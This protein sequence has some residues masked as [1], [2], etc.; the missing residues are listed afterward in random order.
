MDFKNIDKKYRPVPFWSWNEKLDTKET[1]RQI[2]I[3]DKAGIGGYFMHARGGLETEY[4]GKEWFDNVEVGITEG[5]KRGMEAWAYDE[6]GWPSGFG[7]GMVNGLG[8][9]YQQKYLR[10]EKYS[11]HGENTICVKDGYRFYYD[12]NP[13]YVDTLSEEVVA[14]FI[15]KIYKP[16]YEKYG[17]GFKG[18]FTDEPQISRNGIP[19]SLTL[20]NEYKKA[21]GEDLT[22]VLKELFYDVGDYK[23]TRIKFYKL[24]TD[25]FSKNFMKQIYDWCTEHGLEFTGHLVCEDTPA[26]QLLCNGACMPHYEYLHMPGI[27]CLGRGGFPLLP[28]QVSSACHQLGKKAILTETFG[29]SGHGVEFDELKHMTEWQLVRGVTRICPHLEGY[30]LRGIRKRD[31]PPAMYHQ[32]PWWEEYSTFVDAVS[33]TGMLLCE[34]EAKF[35]TLLMHPQTSAWTFCTGFN[36]DEV[37]ERLKKFPEDIR[38]LESKQILFHLGDETLMERH[39]RVEGNELV[40]GCQ[41][42]KRIVLTD[43]VCFMENT[44]RLIDEFRA[45]GGVV[46]TAEEVEAN[47]ICDSRSLTYTCRHFPDFDMHYFVNETKEKVVANISKGSKILNQVT[48]EL[49]PFDGRYT[50][51]KW[52]S[53]VVIDDFSQREELPPKK[54]LKDIDI[55]GKWNV[56]DFGENVLTLDKCDVYFDGCL[57]AEN[58][59]VIEVIDM[60]CALKR[61]VKIRIDYKFNTRHIPDRIYLA[62]EIPH[63]FDISVNGKAFKPNDEGYFVDK[64]FRKLNLEG[65]VT[66]GKNVITMETDYTPPGEL[67]ENIEKALVFESEKNKLTYDVEM[68][69][70]Y[71]IGNFGVSIPESAEELSSNAIRVKDDFAIVEPKKEIVLS[72][73]EKQGFP[74]YA[75]RLT[76]KKTVNLTDSDYKL[77]F[78]KKGVNALKVKVNG[79]DAGTIMWAPFEMDLSGYLKEGD[80]EI[81][82]TVVNNLRNMMGP[83]HHAD[84]ECLTPG[85]IS[86]RKLPSVW[87]NM[88]EMPWNDDY[89]FVE[90]SLE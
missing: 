20:P 57:V 67:L 88:K 61:R 3:M 49:M 34:G 28:L 87:T 60:A 36:T 7:N 85:P 83:H 4:M 13:F 45:N 6:N 17:S 33:R 16:Y 59:S 30:S 74:F 62:C 65:Y 76:L 69:P 66:E 43:H 78:T 72:N 38:L 27:D 15:D 11:S 44:Q 79:K 31:Y 53:I 18:F 64:A 40:I 22:E 48:G 19:W 5:K 39:G 10:C 63:K 90:L 21:Y 58:E 41:R 51:H 2:E 1:A 55:S 75:G 89:C 80:N 14:C 82:I 56:A 50:F 23:N 86:F 73:I 42:Y 32:Q 26:W 24:I 77:K 54:E 9:E 25:L 47:T 37:D 71:I 29:V 84:G 70:V 46:L 12:V 68:E 35:D 81:E 52:E 8:V